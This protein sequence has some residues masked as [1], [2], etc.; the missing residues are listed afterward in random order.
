FVR[1]VE[2]EGFWLRVNGWPLKDPGGF[3]TGGVVTFHDFTE[4]RQA[5]QLLQLLARVVEQTG[6]NVV[7]TDTEG[8]IHY[9]NPAFEATTGYRQAEA[10][11]KTPR[12]LKSGLHDVEFFRQLWA[13]LKDGQ[14]TRGMMINRRKTGELYWS[15]QVITPMR[16]EVGR[17]THFVSVSRDITESKQKKEQEFQLQLARDVQRRFYAA[18]PTVAGFDIGVASHPVYETGGDYFDF[19]C[20]QDGSIMIAMGD[21][22]GHGYGSALVMALTRAYLR[23]FAAMQLELH[24]L[25]ARVNEMLLNDLDQGQFVTLCLAHL[26]PE[27]RTLSYANA[28]HVPGF[29]LLP[30]G[31]VKKMLDSTGRP[32]G[33][34]PDS[35][36]LPPETIILNEGETLIL[37]TDG[38]AEATS[39]DGSEFGTG[40]L[41]DYVR[42][43]ARESAV[44]I[45][46]GVYQAARD[47]VEHDPQDDDITALVVKVNGEIAGETQPGM[48]ETGKN[49][50]IPRWKLIRHTV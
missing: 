41:V 13:R 3:I 16:D 36:F 37:V 48:L 27:E 24:Q 8:K 17:L 4:A 11:G 43:H 7:I 35:E 34:F 2:R 30:S 10:L 9:V 28:G 20:G 47:Y 29:I 50:R 38:I 49:W 18:P 12:I 46:S 39:R 40:R 19:I 21:V 23:S 15:Q 14:T 6:D 31:E 26:Q 32:L 1:G 22:K 5:S 25:L 44:E 33:L 45:A 42:D